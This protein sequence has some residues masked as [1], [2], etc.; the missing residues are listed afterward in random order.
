[1][2]YRECIPSGQVDFTEHYRRGCYQ[3]SMELCGQQTTEITELT[4]TGLRNTVRFTGGC[5]D[6]I[7]HFNFNNIF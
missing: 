2:V 3:E 5:R 7:L 4:C 6:G 1:M